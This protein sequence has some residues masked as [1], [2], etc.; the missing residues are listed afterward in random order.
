MTF[1]AIIMYQKS[2][3]NNNNNN[4]INNNSSNKS[5]NDYTHK[6]CWECASWPRASE[7]KGAQDRCAGNFIQAGGEGGR[8]Q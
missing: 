1:A 8:G 3:N 7:V 2:N 6:T 5:N 4:K